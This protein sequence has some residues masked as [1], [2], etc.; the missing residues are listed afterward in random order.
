MAEKQFK[1]LFFG[2]VPIGPTYPMFVLNLTIYTYL[3]TKFGLN[4]VEM[5]TSSVD[6]YTHVHICTHTYIHTHIQIIF[7]A[8]RYP[9][10]NET[11]RL[12]GKPKKSNIS[13][14]SLSRQIN[15]VMK[16]NLTEMPVWLIT[17]YSQQPLKDLQK[18][19]V[20]IQMACKNGPSELISV[21]NSKF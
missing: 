18:L 11:P 1:I 14:N 19:A 15:E 21:I 6:I 13:Y 5:A 16:P 3:C 7:P 10:R 20:I 4:R 9:W 17:F 8:P 12:L 2:E